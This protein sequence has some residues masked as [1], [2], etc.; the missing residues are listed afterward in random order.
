MNLGGVVAGDGALATAAC[1]ETG[2]GGWPY[3]VPPNQLDCWVACRCLVVAVLVCWVLCCVFWAVRVVV[4]LRV[5]C[6]CCGDS[7]CCCGC[8]GCCCCCG[9]CCGDCRRWRK[10][11]VGAGGGGMS[12]DCRQTAWCEADCCL[13]VEEE[14]WLPLEAKP[15]TTTSALLLA[16]PYSFS[17]TTTYSPTNTHSSTIKQ[18]SFW[19]QEQKKLV[20]N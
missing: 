10:A 13:P 14:T 17:A 9:D 3:A 8:C 5:V 7:W 4:K 2:G 12:C 11:L 15:R 20:S 16:R 19:L 1:G 18:S 6:C